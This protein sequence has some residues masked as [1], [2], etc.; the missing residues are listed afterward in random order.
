MGKLDSVWAGHEDSL[1][2]YLM[3][4]VKWVCESFKSF[5]RS[6][7]L[8][9]LFCPLVTLGR[10]L[11]ALEMLLQ[12]LGEGLHSTSVTWSLGQG[13]TADFH[14]KLLFQLLSAV[15]LSASPTWSSNGAQ[16]HPP[17]RAWIINTR[18][19]VLQLSYWFLSDQLRTRNKQVL[20]D[21]LKIIKQTFGLLN[22]WLWM[23]TILL[24]SAA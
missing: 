19:A 13:C 17:S 10:L 23:L 2:R 16:R 12:A 1:P 4:H 5:I 24:C 18:I 3:N 22:K 20:F 9:Q 11:Q 6:T 7:I 14:I 21:Y 15:L 8:A